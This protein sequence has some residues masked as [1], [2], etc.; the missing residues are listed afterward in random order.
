MN[1]LDA[2]A[3][4]LAALVR[5]ATQGS[6]DA[7]TEARLARWI[8]LVES[9]NRRIDL[10]AARDQRE[11]V[12]LMLADALVLAEHVPR[13]ARVVDVGSGAGA[14]GL[15]LALARPDLEVTLVEPLA[16]RATFLRTTVGSLG[17]RGVTVR[18]ARGE[19]L[20]R[21]GERFDVACSRATLA[22][23]EWAALGLSLAPEVWV[24]LAR[25][26]VP[27]VPG[28]RADLELP[29]EWPLTKAER[30]AARLRAAPTP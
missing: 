12:D 14:P 17:T 20:A 11:L 19:E 26:E 22:P 9:W 18:R 27:V 29:Y 28:A 2:R 3:N 8:A 6:L 30:R 23:R 1:D 21:D 4:E 13:G 5:A 15:G 25:G 16:K 24:L 10:T 7:P